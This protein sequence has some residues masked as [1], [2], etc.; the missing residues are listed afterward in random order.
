MQ[1]P[2]N[3]LSLYESPI[4]LLFFFNLVG[5][6]FNEAFPILVQ[7]PII[8]FKHLSYRQ[9]YDVQFA[10]HDCNPLPLEGEG[11]NHK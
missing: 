10:C 8:D 7:T 9:V 6:F 4:N 1:Y 11:E 2:C 3:I 5:L